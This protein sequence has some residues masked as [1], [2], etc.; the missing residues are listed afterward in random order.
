M[1]AKL[2]GTGYCSADDHYNPAENEEE[3]PSWLRVGDIGASISVVGF[4]D[5][6]HWE[7][8]VAESLIRNFFSS[9]NNESVIFDVNGKYLLN[10]LN[11]K[12]LFEN[13]KISNADEISGSEGFCFSY[14]LYRCLVSE[15][16]KVFKRDIDGFGRFKLNILVEDGLEK[17]VGFIRNGMYITNELSNFK[18]KLKRFPALK[19][20]V[21]VIEPIND[22]SISAL[23]SVENPKHDEFSP[24]RI[25][26]PN[27][28]KA[29]IKK[30]G[31][32]SDW[33]KQAIKDLT[34]PEPKEE[35]LI[36]ELND[37]FSMPGQ[38]DLIDSDK[39]ENNPETVSVE[40][41]K[42]KVSSV[43][44]SSNQNSDFDD[45]DASEGEGDNFRQ[46]HGKNTNEGGP[47]NRGGYGGGKTTPTNKEKSN[48]KKEKGVVKYFE[49]RT[50]I[51]DSASNRIIYLTP[52]ETVLA[53]L[54]IFTP[55]LSKKEELSIKDVHDSRFIGGYY[56][57]QL[58][59]GVRSLIN[60]TFTTEYDGPIIVKLLKDKGDAK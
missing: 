60:L 4:Q 29:I 6:E 17:K 19:D 7:E 5:D 1:K 18:D 12:S 47:Y 54:R 58:N 36:S 43:N 14:S 56:Y 20:F 45:T 8:R 28:Q 48:D 42:V 25:D 35:D 53:Q 16:S 2:R 38:S 52:A 30:F 10:K 24:S 32:L 23:R 49:L 3:I 22:L 39:G 55:G 13:K 26:D 40:K 37:F 31:I 21:A 27:K 57:I 44:D 11:L 41:I 9:I 50:I 46:G 15:H 33:A 59:S 51:G 34:T